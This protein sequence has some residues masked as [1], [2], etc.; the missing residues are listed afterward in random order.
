MVHEKKTRQQGSVMVEYLILLVLVATGFCAA[1]V[2]MG[3]LL[4][5]KYMEIELVLSLPFP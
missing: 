1:L 4:L 3:A 5:G 2:P